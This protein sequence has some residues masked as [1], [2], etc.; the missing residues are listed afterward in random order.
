MKQLFLLLMMFIF[1]VSIVFGLSVFS[2]N[3]ENFLEFVHIP[4]TAGT[5]I[6]NI[7]NEKNIK[8]G[9]MKPSHRD[10]LKPDHPNC[11]YWHLPPKYF[12]ND[13]HYHKDNDGTFCVIRDPFDRIVSEYKYKNGF[14]N[15]PKHMN[16]W[17]KEHLIPKY[18]KGGNNCHFLPQYEFVYDELGTKTCDHILRF[19]N[20]TEDFNKL[21]NKFNID[22]KLEENRKDNVSNN[23]L[24][25]ND[26][27]E[28]NIRLIREIYSNDFLL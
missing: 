24:S 4:K 25:V 5:T 6:E 8:W 17:I 2:R 19:D 1:F 28:E 27:N 13:S 23:N 18:T 11:T 10:Y 9:R 20:L 22:L 12:Y 7:A 26:L 16:D 3:K 15:D 14:S 21:T